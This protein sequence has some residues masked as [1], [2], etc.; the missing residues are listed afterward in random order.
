MYQNGVWE[1]LDTFDSLHSVMWP[2]CVCSCN[3]LFCPS[4]PK[5]LRTCDSLFTPVPHKY[6]RLSLLATVSFI[7]HVFQRRYFATDTAYVYPI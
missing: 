6:F 2:K 5:Y 1:D 3:C 4:L 7:D